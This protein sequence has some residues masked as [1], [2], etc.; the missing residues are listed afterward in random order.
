MCQMQYTDKVNVHFPITSSKIFVLKFIKMI[1]KKLMKSMIKSW[2]NNKVTY[3]FT[4]DI[5]LYFIQFQLYF[6]SKIG[7]NQNNS[8]KKKKANQIQ[9]NLVKEILNYH[10]NFYF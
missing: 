7:Q 5:S 6:N 8:N 3:S 2:M 10:L 4:T 1:P 9:Q